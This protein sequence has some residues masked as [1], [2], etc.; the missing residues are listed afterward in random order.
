MCD[1]LY[2]SIAGRFLYGTAFGRAEGFARKGEL[3]TAS[4]FFGIITGVN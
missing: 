3:Q 4:S 1:V 2:G